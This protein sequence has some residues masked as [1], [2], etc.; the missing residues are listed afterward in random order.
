MISVNFNLYTGEVMVVELPE[1]K[2]SMGYSVTTMQPEL[3][4]EQTNRK[5]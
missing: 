5:F 4:Q 1:F 2:V 3:C